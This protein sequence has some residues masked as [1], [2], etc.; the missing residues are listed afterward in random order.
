MYNG[1]L[2][3]KEHSAEFYSRLLVYSDYL[4]IERLSEIC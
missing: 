2:S 1:D 4:M 3:I